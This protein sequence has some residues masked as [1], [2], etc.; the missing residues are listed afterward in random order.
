V[1]VPGIGY[2]ILEATSPDPNQVI[3]IFIEDSIISEG[4]TTQTPGPI[5]TAEPFRIGDTISIA[6]GIIVDHNGN[7]VPDSTIVRFMLYHDTESVPAQVVES[8]TKQGVAQGNLTID[9]SGEINIQAESGQAVTSDVINLE[10]PP[11]SITLTPIPP[12]PVPTSTLTPTIIPTNTPFPTPTNTPVPVIVSNQGSIDFGDWLA[13]LVVIA[14]VSGGNYWIINT[15]RGLRWG[16][17]AALLPIIGGTITYIY[18]AI[19]MPGS[20]TM[21]QNLGTWSIVIFSIIGSAIGVGAVLFW[22]YID[23]RKI[24]PA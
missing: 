14:I 4:E 20:E 18:L 2:E 17:R 6:T 22:H 19:N 23:N 9:Q 1:S 8:Q 10:I 21:I 16:V 5:S 11:E 12:T 13:A 7:Q 15:K 3:H 24:K